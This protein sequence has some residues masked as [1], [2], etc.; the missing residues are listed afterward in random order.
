MSK[1]IKL[2]IALLVVTVIAVIV[3]LPCIQLS[4]FRLPEKLGG[5]GGERELVIIYGPDLCLSCPSGQYV[6]SLRERTDLIFVVPSH[7]ETHDIENLKDVFLISGVIRR[8]GEEIDG[9][10]E[11]ICSCRG[12]SDSGVNFHLKIGENGKLSSVKP[13]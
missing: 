3:Y 2:L 12:V 11:K 9:V 7:Y 8:G 5:T 13:F 6:Y 1:W 10:L 4:F